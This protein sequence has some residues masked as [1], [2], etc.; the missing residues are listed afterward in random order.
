MRFR[1]SLAAVTVASVSALALA[2]L[3]LATAQT[4]GEFTISNFTDFHGRWEQKLDEENPA[5]SIPGAVA[6]KCAADRAAGT[7]AHAL[8]SSGDNI[9]ASPFA[10]MIL[11]DEPTIEVLNQMG[12]DVSTVGNH[13]FDK[14]ADDLVN[15]VVPEADWT[16]LAAGADGLD[17]STGIKD[18]KIMNLNGVNVAFIG[19]VTDDMPNLVSP[20]G[21]QGITWQKPVD[22]INKLA[23]ELTANKEADVV[24]AMPHAG[25][26]PATAWSANVDAVFM[27]HTH[28]F[29]E[30]TGTTPIVFQAGSYSQGLANVDFAYDK[31]ND[32]LSLQKAELLRPA[33]IIACDTPNA[34]MQTTIDTAK[35]EAKDAGAEVIG[36]LDQSLY[37]GINGDASGSENRGVESQLNN[38]LANVAKWG[39]ANNSTVTPDIGVMNAGGV[40]ADLQAGEVTYEEAFSVQPFGNEITYTTLKGSDFLEAL[41]QQWREPT[42]GRPFLSLGVSDNVSY[43][44]DPTRPQGERITNV[45]IDGAPIDPAK[46]YVVAGSTYL[47]AGGDSFTALANGADVAQLGY[48][49]I[50]AFKEYLDAYLGGKG[51]PAPRTGQS[52]VGL[53]YTEPIVAGKSHAFELTSLIY[54]Q[55]ET[56][57]NVTVELGGAKQTVAI[58]SDFGP[59]GY[60]EAGKA[61][62]TLTVPADV[63]GEQQLRITTDAGTDISVPVTVYPTNPPAPTGSTEGFGAGSAIG[64]LSTIAAV[65]AAIVAA[66]GGVLATQPQLLGFLRMVVPGFPF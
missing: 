56:A 36:T 4:T 66:V 47:L 53:Q 31:A 7:R 61:T 34:E 6:L 41:E 29:V 10:S 54:T 43:S 33:D 21:I 2:G 48:V 20:A 40:R 62:V 35:N 52:N 42:E 32:K 11:D 30:Q 45:L 55:G 59:A 26:I 16:Y 18:Y 12:L 38:L 28:E 50:Q 37:R 64:S 13:E 60:N 44:Y 17:R 5:N 51:A 49:D 65:V 58:D 25:G 15:R 3:P 22:A 14:G 8:T 27:G 39:V 1:P 23:D 9:G 63:V 24:I 46:D 19:A 57:E